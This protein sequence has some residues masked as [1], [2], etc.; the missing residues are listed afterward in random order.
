M[1]LSAST[2]VYAPSFTLSCIF[3][4][5]PVSASV[6][7]RLTAFVPASNTTLNPR[8]SAKYLSSPILFTFIL[9]WNSP[10]TSPS[11]AIYERRVSISVLYSFTTGYGLNIVYPSPP[12]AMK[13]FVTTE[14]VMSM[15]IAWPFIFTSVILFAGS[16]PALRVKVM[17]A[18]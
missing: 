3:D 10:F 12:A 8:D 15:S 2:A 17:P 5:A 1:L 13:S 16:V 7:I 9:V 4:P 18:T 14:Y 11:S 6:F